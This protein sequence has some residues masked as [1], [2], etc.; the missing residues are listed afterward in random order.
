M[1]RCRRRAFS[2]KVQ[3]FIGGKDD[4]SITVHVPVGDVADTPVRQLVESDRG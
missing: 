1:V 4:S 2:Y 3:V